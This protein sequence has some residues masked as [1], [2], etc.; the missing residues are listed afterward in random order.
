MCPG[1]V[2]G[3]RIAM[4]GC[5]EIGID[6][7]RGSKALIVFVEIDRCATD[8]IQA[9]TGCS[10]G[11]RSLKYIDY[12]KMAATFL[13]TKTGK[14][15]RVIALEE[16]RER[17]AGYAPNEQDRHKTQTAAY[18]VMPESELLRL[19]AVD[20]ALS[21][22][23]QPGSPLKRVQCEECG[24][25]IN[26]GREVLGDGLTLCRSCAGGAYYSRVST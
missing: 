1:Q 13:N 26:D 21:P 10:L 20:V 14:A 12:G 4:A 6:E 11:K 9:V 3:V 15:V 24:E 2:L 22:M 19:E 7:P 17:A 25:G 18:Q 16:S 5:R 23:D 8:A